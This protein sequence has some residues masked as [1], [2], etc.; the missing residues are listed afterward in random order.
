[1]KSKLALVKAKRFQVL[2]EAFTSSPPFS[3]LSFLPS[4]SLA[5]PSPK[6]AGKNRAFKNFSLPP[7]A[8]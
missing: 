6:F 1:M 2:E 3:P 4:S 7:T 5:W 8:V